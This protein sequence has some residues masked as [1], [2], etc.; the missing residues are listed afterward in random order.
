MVGSRPPALV[1]ESGMA[2]DGPTPANVNSR[3]FIIEAMQALGRTA[4]AVAVDCRASLRVPKHVMSGEQLR[5]DKEGE[6]GL[7]WRI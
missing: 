5:G 2:T 7:G 6:D 4:L 1:R 3:R